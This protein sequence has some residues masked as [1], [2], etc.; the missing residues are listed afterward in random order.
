M[1]S[2]ALRCT[3][4][5]CHSTCS[6]GDNFIRDEALSSRVLGPCKHFFCADLCNRINGY[7]YGM[8]QPTVQK[9]RTSTCLVTCRFTSRRLINAPRARQTA[10]RA[11]GMPGEISTV[12]TRPV[13]SPVTALGHSRLPNR[14]VLLLSGILCRCFRPLINLALCHVHPTSLS[15]A[16]KFELALRTAI[17]LRRC[18]YESGLWFPLIVHIGTI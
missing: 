3:S 13:V 2:R 14:L 15:S 16:L 1:R 17:C 11:R 6:L 4:D 10:C 8:G 7:M 9:A 5:A 12:V 18:T